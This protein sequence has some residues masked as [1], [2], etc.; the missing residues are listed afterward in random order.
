MLW[1]TGVEENM[2]KYN[3]AYSCVHYLPILPMAVSRP[4]EKQFYSK[5]PSTLS[6]RDMIKKHTKLELLF[7]LVFRSFL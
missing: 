1:G 5:S 4:I 7:P 3:E 6:R 2:I